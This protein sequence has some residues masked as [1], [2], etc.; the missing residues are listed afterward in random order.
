MWCVETLVWK[1]SS[2]SRCAFYFMDRSNPRLCG[3]VAQ[4]AEVCSTH[5]LLQQQQWIIADFSTT[6]AKHV[7]NLYPRLTEM[8]NEGSKAFYKDP[9]ATGVLMPVCS[10]IC[11]QSH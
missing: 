2:E 6:E 5:L 1:S 8:K 9:N 11:E 4:E 10:S 7:A 3:K